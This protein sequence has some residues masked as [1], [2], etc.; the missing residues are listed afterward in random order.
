MDRDLV[1]WLLH[2]R[3]VQMHAIAFRAPQHAACR[4]LDDDLKVRAYAT[5]FVE[6]VDLVFTRAAVRDRRIVS[7]CDFHR[8]PDTSTATEAAVSVRHRPILPA[9]PRSKQPS[10]H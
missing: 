8:P 6:A 1:S 9:G 7:V 3:Q 10:A 4:L 2:D 5:V